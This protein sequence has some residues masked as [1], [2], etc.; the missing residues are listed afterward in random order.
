MDELITIAH[1]EIGG[2]LEE[3]RTFVAESD[4]HAAH[5]SIKQAIEIDPQGVEV[6]R[7]AAEIEEHL[8]LFDDALTHF[9]TAERDGQAG[10]LVEFLTRRIL[11]ASPG[12]P[13]E[14]V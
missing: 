2:F 1:P 13:V 6:L 9:R 5:D 7:L 11:R 10:A 12:D 14:V 3:A 8:G 4:W